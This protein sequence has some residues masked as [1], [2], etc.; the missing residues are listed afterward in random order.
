MASPYDEPFTSNGAFAVDL[1]GR[2][3]QK[4]VSLQGPVL[5]DRDPEP[6]HQMRVSLRRLR[7]C[8]QQFAPA[9]RLPRAVGDPRLAKMVRRLGMARDLDVLRQRL[10]HDLI[11]ELPD[12]ERRAL[13]PVLK[14]LRRERALAYEQLVTALHSGG[15]LKLLSQL[16][17]WLR[18][19]D[20]TPLGALPLRSWSQEWQAPM[21][22]G[23]FQHPGWFIADRQGDMELV[24]DLRKRLK[25]ARYGLENLGA[26]TGS[27]CRQ[28]IAELRDLQELLGELN[29]LHVLEKAIDDQLPSGLARSVPVLEA[30]L[31]G[32]AQACWGQWR[33]RADGLVRPER[34]R[35]LSMALLER[36]C[37]GQPQPSLL[38][39]PALPSS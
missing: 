38:T 4:L 6:L 28:W 11:G 20:L 13:R 37:Q 19:P 1:I 17:G 39:S 27:R 29:D 16:Q 15:Y 32:R 14:Q 35:S 10:E 23:L 9:L 18:E 5:A 34:R 22:A 26:V 33:Q 2:H 31:R 7:T 21:V 24:H 25:T 12:G 3:T 8:L 30:L 36:R